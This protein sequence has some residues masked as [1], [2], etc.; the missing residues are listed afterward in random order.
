MGRVK[1]CDWSHLNQEKCGTW[2]TIVVNFGYRKVHTSDNPSFN[3]RFT[4][5]IFQSVVYLT[6]LHVEK[7]PTVQ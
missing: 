6:L 2:P 1:M 4:P 3:K 7:L 5:Q